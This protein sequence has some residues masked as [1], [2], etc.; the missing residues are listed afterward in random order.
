MTGSQK[1]KRVQLTLND[2]DRPMI[3]GILSSDPDYKLSMKINRKLNLKLKSTEPVTIKIND[4]EDISFSRFSDHT[5]A[6]ESAVS[7]VSNRSGNNFLLK[8][9]KNLDFILLIHGESSKDRSAGIS[10][11]LREID[12][13]TGVFMTGPDIFKDKNLKFLL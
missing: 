8:K 4:S 9:L 10:S 12:T 11:S 3:L 6:A 13:I 7:L 5:A 2:Q 1:I